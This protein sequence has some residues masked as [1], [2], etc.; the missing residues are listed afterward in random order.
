MGPRLVR[1][2]LEVRNP[3]LPHVHR[4]TRRQSPPVRTAFAPLSFHLCR[5]P[6]I[7]MQRERLDGLDP[8]LARV[9]AWLIISGVA[10]QLGQRLPETLSDR[11]CNAFAEA[12]VPTSLAETVEMRLA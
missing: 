8:A 4:N 9:R 6:L 3:T 5:S 1:R 12:R 2:L 10:V 11:F 7:Q